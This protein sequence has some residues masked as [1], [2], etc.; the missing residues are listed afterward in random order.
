MIKMKKDT[1]KMNKL[2]EESFQIKA[3]YQECWAISLKYSSILVKNIKS[4]NLL[5]SCNTVYGQYLHE[6]QYKNMNVKDK[7]HIKDKNYVQ[8]WETMINTISKDYSKGIAAIRLLHQTNV[9]K[10]N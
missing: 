4:D 10:N 7:K 2:R 5:L 6:L 8:I 9:Q 1:S 3:D